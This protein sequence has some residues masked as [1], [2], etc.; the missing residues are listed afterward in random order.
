VGDIDRQFGDRG[1]RVVFS[2]S[3]LG[4]TATL[5]LIA[6]LLWFC[7]HPKPPDLAACTRIEVHY[8][9][10]ALDYFIPH[11]PAQNSIL[12]EDERRYIE[13][14]DT[15]TVTDP[16]QIKAFAHDISQGA[17]RRKEPRHTSTDVAVVCYR[18]EERVASFDV[19]RKSI[20]TD[21]QNEFEYPLGLPDPTILDP[22]GMKPLKARWECT[23]NLMS[24][25]YEGL[26]PVRDRR[27]YPDPNHWCDAIVGAFRHQQVIYTGQQIKRVRAYSDTAIARR[28]TCPSVHAATDV[29]DAHSQPHETKSSSQTPDTWISD[30]AMNS[31]CRKDSPGDIVFLFESKPGWN[32]HGGPELFT[33]ANH[34]P[35]GGCVLLNDGKVKF[36]RT[37]EE[38]K[39]LRWK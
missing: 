22:P 31:S 17:Y 35:K 14:F 21:D 33:F 1:R 27:P 25:I 18:G 39:Q 16:K 28:F 36:I 26:W 37:E 30:Y 32:Q 13:S 7:S 29:N 20:R 12:S 10:G 19:L 5:S 3:L 34:D 9:G 2:A 6:L 11:T 4:I 24:L 15:W 23:R 8:R 38:L